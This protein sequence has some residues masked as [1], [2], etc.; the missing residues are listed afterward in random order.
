MV[1]VTVN[2]SDEENRI[3]EYHRIDCGLNNKRESIKSVIVEFAKLRTR[4][5]R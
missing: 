2:L 3:V 1:L 5:K 4:R